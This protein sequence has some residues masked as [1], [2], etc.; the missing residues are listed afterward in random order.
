MAIDW[1]YYHW[2]LEPSA[3][4]A[5]HCPRCP[6]TEHPD[7]PWLNKHMDFDFFKSFMTPDM[8]T[9]KVRR[10]T[11]CGD[12]GD[13]IYCKDYI[14]IYKYIK[15]INPKIHVYTITNGS[16]RATTWWQ[17]L[18]EV[19][20]SYDTINFGIDGYDN[21][22]N[23]LYRVGSNWDSIINGIRT[24]R[25]HNQDIFLNWAVIM[26]KFNE[27]Y[28]DNIVDQ[29]T[30]LGMDAV[31]V[32]KSTKF[33]SKYGG[34]YHGSDDPLE[35]SSKWVSSTHR[36]ERSMIHL[37][38]RRQANQLY[39]DHNYR[40]YVEIKQQYATAPIVP[41]CEIGNRGLYVNAEG[42]VFPCSWTSFPYKSLSDGDKTIQWQDSFFAQ[43]RDRMN[44]RNRSLEEILADPLWSKCSQGWRDPN[45]TWVEC[46]QKCSNQLV[47]EEYAV[48]W[49]TN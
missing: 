47:T 30:A 45:K 18:A 17:Q 14:E 21:E 23:N 16:N 4:C 22:S 1:Q 37:N 42:V 40:K 27:D 19:A 5:L 15:S 43:Y 20:N 11:M 44:L 10:I 34:A 2:H 31:Q 36:Y 6:R 32:T 39:L 9:H 46:S 3:V 29:A 38:A 28:L 35:P 12:V 48:G 26:F 8:L 24:V 41:L 25:K 13:P 33:G 49:E 7:T